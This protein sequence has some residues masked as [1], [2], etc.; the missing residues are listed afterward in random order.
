MKFKI[1]GIEINIKKETIGMVV[2][3]IIFTLLAVV[4]AYMNDRGELVFSSDYDGN[5][6]QKLNPD[7]NENGSKGDDKHPVEK[8]QVY[9]TGCVKNPGVVTLEKGQI[10]ADAIEAAGGFTEDADLE[11]INLVYQLN[12]N[13]MLRIKSR[14]QNEEA[15][16][17][18]I[19]EAG[20]GIEMIYGS[21]GAV[22]DYTGKQEPNLININTAT[23]L[24][25]QS[26]PGIGEQTAK[27]I[28]EY[29]N[30]N[31][32]FEKIEDIMKVPGIKENKFEDIKDLITV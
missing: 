23:V 13:V 24:E 29:R 20:S 19:S 31:G 22:V 10:I 1:R 18:E 26:L 4:Y 30:R 3:I 2:A 28:V 15:K 32:S 27:S 9:V 16:G 25:L 8:I 6:F 5:S 12:R 21:G 17:G 14:I 7:S 11:N